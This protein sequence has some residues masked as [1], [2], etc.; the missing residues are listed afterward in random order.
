V[1][2]EPWLRTALRPSRKSHE[3]THANV[4]SGQMRC[5]CR[6]AAGAAATRLTSQRVG[7][8][9]SAGRPSVRHSAPLTL[10]QTVGYRVSGAGSVCSTGI[11][12]HS[13]G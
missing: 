10:S 3:L 8:N 11:R 1:S 6:L 4:G 2:G 13:T 9:P 7:S 5:P 12:I